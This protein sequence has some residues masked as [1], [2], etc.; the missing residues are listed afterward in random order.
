MTSK[1]TDQEKN[2]QLVTFMDAPQDAE[3]KLTKEATITTQAEFDRLRELN[4][5]SKYPSNRR[6]LTVK[7]ALARKEK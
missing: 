4:S 3:R 5:M 1:M 2:V 6:K 7:I